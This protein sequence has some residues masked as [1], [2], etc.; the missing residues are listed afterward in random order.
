MPMHDVGYRA[1]KG[2]LTSI[3]SRWWMIAQTGIAIAFRSQW[4]KRMLLAAWMPIVAIGSFFFV[5][6]NYLSD[7]NNKMDFL[8]RSAAEF[9]VDLDDPESR[10]E[11]LEQI[12]NSPP[13]RRLDRAT[14]GLGPGNSRPAQKKQI[15]VPMENTGSMKKQISQII[16]DRNKQIVD[17]IK[18]KCRELDVDVAKPKIKKL[19]DKLEKSGVPI[20]FNERILTRYLQRLDNAKTRERL[21]RQ[22][23]NLSEQ[24]EKISKLDPKDLP[25]TDE[26]PS[27]EDLIRRGQ[28]LAPED[29]F[30]FELQQMDLNDSLP[31]SFIVPYRQKIVEAWA[32]PD[33]AKARVLGWSYFLMVFLGYPQGVATI[34]LLALIVPPLISRDLRSRAYFIYF[35]KP[36]GRFE[37]LFGKFTIPLVFLVLITTL[38]ALGLYIF[39]VALSPDL[40]VVLDTWYLPLKIVLAS[41]VMIVPTVSVALMLSSLTQESRFATFAMFAIWS[42]TAGAYMVMWGFHTSNELTNEIREQERSES[43]VVVNMYDVEGNVVGQRTVNN[44]DIDLSNVRPLN[45]NWQMISFYHS[46]QHIQGWIFGLVPFDFSVVACGGMLLLTTIFSWFVL[47]WRVSAPIRV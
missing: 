31:P 25:I 47:Y 29:R 26:L 43:T 20:A 45:S 38:P 17:K 28:Q 16:A 9:G 13:L 7:R 3:I 41:A 39:A 24:V 4:I 37:Y 42:L 40:S 8:R 21:E 10:R 46:S 15:V 33:N 30:K 22:L 34:I 1:W 18:E 2:E 23:D 19:F 44:Q 6:E 14:T 5:F 35:A 36:I 32:T 12:K 11:Y 27:V